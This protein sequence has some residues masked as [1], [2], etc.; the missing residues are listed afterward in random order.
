MSKDNQQFIEIGQLSDEKE[1]LMKRKF[2]KGAELE[3]KKSKSVGG[4]PKKQRKA[5]KFISIYVTEDEKKKINEHADRINL[6]VSSY[7]RNL[8]SKEGII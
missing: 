6:S 5:E 2:A 4:R 7:I 3:N 1:E 8:L